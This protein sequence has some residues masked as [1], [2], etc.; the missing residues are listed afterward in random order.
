MNFDKNNIG[1][2]GRRFEKDRRIFFVSKSLITFFF[3]FPYV[4]KKKPDDF[5]QR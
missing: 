1:G 4:K 2:H 3:D 5:W